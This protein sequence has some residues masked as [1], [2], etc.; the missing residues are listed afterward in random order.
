MADVAHTTRHARDF[1]LESR[2]ELN[3]KEAPS[4]PHN[5]RP[6]TERAVF[7]LPQCH[8]DGFNDYKEPAPIYLYPLGGYSSPSLS[9]SGSPT[10]RPSLSLS[11][12]LYDYTGIWLYSGPRKVSVRATNLN[13]IKRQSAKTRRIQLG[14][15]IK[16]IY[17]NCCVTTNSKDL[18][19][20]GHSN[21]KEFEGLLNK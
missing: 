20:F 19:S 1:S 9:L 3:Q 7:Q 21:P 16:R 17:P 6:P 10:R 5:W 11:G 2:I 12:G 18:C 13:L 8:R 4:E 15:G 14:I